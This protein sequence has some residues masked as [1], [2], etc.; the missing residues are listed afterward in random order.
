MYKIVDVILRK[1]DPKEVALINHLLQKEVVRTDFVK[2][3]LR[4]KIFRERYKVKVAI[5]P[6][7][8]YRA[9]TR[10][11]LKIQLR[12]NLARESDIYEYL[13]PKK[14]TCT[15]SDLVRLAM[16]EYL[17]LKEKDFKIDVKET[18]KEIV[19]GGD[20]GESRRAKKGLPF[21]VI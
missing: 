11:D 10:E 12:L 19:V 13:N 20:V 5:E 9:K 21:V 7:E 4:D 16:I 15:K 14:K 2:Q 1:H 6:I 18:A 17:Y 8:E 3:A